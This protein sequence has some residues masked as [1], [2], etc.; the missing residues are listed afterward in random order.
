MEALRG[1]NTSLTEVSPPPGVAPFEFNLTARVKMY[2]GS[3][4]AGPCVG[5][6]GSGALRMASEWQLDVIN[7]ENGLQFTTGLVLRMG[8]W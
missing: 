3:D 8:T 4:H 6:G 2:M 5:G 1:R 7:Y